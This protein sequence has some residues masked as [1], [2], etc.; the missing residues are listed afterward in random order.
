[1]SF[2]ISSQC[3]HYMGPVMGRIIGLP[4]MVVWLYF[5]VSWVCLRFGI[6]VFPD[7][8]HLLFLL[9]KPIPVQ[10]WT[11]VYPTRYRSDVQLMGK[12][13]SLQSCLQYLADIQTIWWLD[14]GS[15]TGSRVC[16]ML[17]GPSL[18][19][20]LGIL[21]MASLPYDSMWLTSN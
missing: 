5:V 6:V 21:L 11:N 3:A 9:T 1:M 18:V 20:P 4:V 10:Y 17:D 8:T 15:L 2:T 16:D 7:H 12:M 14:I 13:I 19:R